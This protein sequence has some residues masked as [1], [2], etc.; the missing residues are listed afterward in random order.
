MFYNFYISFRTDSYYL[1]FYQKFE[2]NIFVTSKIFEGA[3]LIQTDYSVL[4][5]D[6]DFIIPSSLNKCINFLKNNKSYSSAHGLYFNHPNIDDFKKTNIFKFVARHRGEVCKEN[7]PLDRIRELLL[8]RE[9]AYL[10]KADLIVDTEL[11]G[12]E[13]VAY[14]IIEGLDYE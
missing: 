5:A 9:C 3:S 1:L 8:E 14:K 13:E 11:F 12:P 6:D 10:C 7:N 2:S 4:C